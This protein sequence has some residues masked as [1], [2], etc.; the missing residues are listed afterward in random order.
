MSGTYHLAELKVALD[1]ASPNHI[2]PPSCPPDCK[3]LD[4]GCGAGQTL[5]AAYPDRMSFGIDIDE[6]ALRLG[7]TLTQQVCFARARVEALPFPDAHFDLVIARVS[8]MYADFNGGLAEIRRVLK[9][10]GTVWMTLHT[11]SRTWAKAKRGNYRAKLYFLYIA[12]NSLWFH[13]VQ[14]NFSLLGRQESFQ[15]KRGVMAALRKHQFCD[16][17]IS[18]EN[19]FLVIAQKP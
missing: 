4:V 5:I 1:S 2:A 12:A 16:V 19:H 6:G 15:T 13:M 7:K 3:I 17:S 18:L 11:F 9:S 14:R 8:L 10:G